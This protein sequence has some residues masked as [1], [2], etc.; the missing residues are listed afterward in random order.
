MPK[1]ALPMLCVSSVSMM[2]PGTMNAPYSTPSTACIRLPI[3]PPNTMKY[4]DVVMTGRDAGSATGSAAR[5]PFRSDRSPRCRAGSCAAAS[6]SPTKISSRLDLDVSRSRKPMPRS[7]EAAQQR[8]DAG[9]LGLRVE[10][11]SAGGA[12][13][14]SASDPIPP[15]RAGPPPAARCSVRSS[16]RLPELRHQRGLVLDQQQLAAR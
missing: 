7:C 5:A 4:S 14:R 10:D 2:R 9:A 12:P 11:C 16:S 3:A 13:R 1:I 8:G 6:T 15:V